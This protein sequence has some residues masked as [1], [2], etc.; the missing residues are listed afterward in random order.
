VK[1][2]KVI[3]GEVSGTEELEPGT[4][5]RSQMAVKYAAKRK[6]ALKATDEYLAELVVKVG[7]PTPEQIARAEA[8]VKRI[9]E[10]PL[11]RRPQP[12]FLD[13]KSR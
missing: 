1:R 9:L 8:I 11:S 6:A 4:G 13:Q 5:R 10:R 12:T 3:S 2:T 7:E